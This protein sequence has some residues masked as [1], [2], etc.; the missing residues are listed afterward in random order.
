L[1]NDRPA[2][3]GS[4]SGEGD[5]VRVL[6]VE[7]EPIVALLLRLVLENRGYSV[8]DV[9]SG[10]DALSECGRWAPGVIVADLS[11][12]DASAADFVARLRAEVGAG[13][14]LVIGTSP[15]SL[16]VPGIAALFARPFEAVEVAEKV[17]CLIG[18]KEDGRA[19]WCM[20][21]T[22][23]L[24]VRRQ[25]LCEIWHR[26]TA[27]N[28]Q[29]EHCD[30]ESDATLNRILTLLSAVVDRATKNALHSEVVSG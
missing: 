20:S 25:A 15:N 13:G 17:A 27:I 10:A 11:V 5:E 9:G 22:A 19:E 6:V 23:A 18:E 28:R 21:A 26:L 29:I 30:S 8:R 24:E 12:A 7:S 2:S 14:L 1:D 16:Q 4:P 3:Q